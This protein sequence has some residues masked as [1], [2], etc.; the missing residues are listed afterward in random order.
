MS[1]REY[2]EQLGNVCCVCGRTDDTLVIHHVKTQGARPDLK[3][4]I[5]N[6]CVL[7]F[8]C[9]Y[10]LEHRTKKDYINK[11]IQEHLKKRYGK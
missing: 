8:H 9:H 1:Y 7:C 10:G 2:L 4:D 3:N 6:M 5:S 11:K